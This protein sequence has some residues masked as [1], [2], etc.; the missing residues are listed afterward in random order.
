MSLRPANKNSQGR[1][2]PEEI[3][4]E[5]EHLVH[6]A[7]KLEVDE[8]EPSPIKWLNEAHKET[9]LKSG[10][11]TDELARQIRAY[12]TLSELKSGR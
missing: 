6:H 1:V 4:A 11:L 7:S 10:M 2:E 9:L 8:F 5:H 12:E 3:G